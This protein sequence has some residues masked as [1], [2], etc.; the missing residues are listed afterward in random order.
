M[1]S[2]I[3]RKKISGH[4]AISLCPVTGIQDSTS[5]PDADG[6]FDICPS[7]ALIRGRWFVI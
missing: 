3:L 2:T 7:F 6:G 4:P 5:F 1:A